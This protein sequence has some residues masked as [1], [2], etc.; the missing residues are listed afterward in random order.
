[1]LRTLTLCAAKALAMGGAAFAQDH[2]AP[3]GPAAASA[4]A[5]PV[6]GPNPNPAHPMGGYLKAPDGS[7]RLVAKKYEPAVGLP[8]YTLDRVCRSQCAVLFPPLT[9]AAGARPPS[10]DWTIVIRDEGGH[11]QWAYKGKPIYTFLQDKTDV[12]PQADSVLPE[13]KLARP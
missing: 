7:T 3:A 10:R 4:A 12:H 13:V 11:P 5:E 9:P 2:A 1:M 8:L 6:F